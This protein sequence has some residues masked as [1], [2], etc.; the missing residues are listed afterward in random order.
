MKQKIHKLYGSRPV[1]RPRRRTRREIERLKEALFDV[2]SENNPATVRQVFYLTVAQGLIPKT[3]LEYRRISDFLSQMRRKDEIPWYWIVD[4]SRVARKPRIF[5][6]A[7]E[8]IEECARFY[9]KDIWRNLPER[10]E[11]WTEKETLTGPL[12]SVTYRLAVGLFPCRGFASL[13]FLY[14]AAKEIEECGKPTTIYYF[15]DHDPSGQN[16]FQTIQRDLQKLAPTTD[17][18]FE[19]LA[20]TY[21]QIER[22]DLPTR[23]TKR[24]DSRSKNFKGESVEVEAIAPD[25]LRRLCEDAIKS[26]IPEGHLKQVEMIEASERR[27]ILSLV[28]TVNQ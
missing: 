2:L 26:H 27:D 9:R 4:H 15:G 14:E 1:N 5:G 12:L 8:A 6:T 7:A 18:Y 3:E 25:M 28:K 13:S 24:T 21:E 23:P 19:K 20:V 22:W 11:I 16:I 10:V 17:I